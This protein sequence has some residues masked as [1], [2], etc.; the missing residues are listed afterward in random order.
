MGSVPFLNPVA[1]FRRGNALLERGRFA[2][3]E[4]CYRGVLAV[5]PDHLAAHGNLGFALRE[6][7]RHAE[8]EACY[9]RVAEACPEDAEVHYHYGNLLFA[10]GRL[11]EAEAAFRRALEIEP[12][13]ASTHNNLGATLKDLGRYAEAES[14][15]RRALEIQPDGE[16]VHRHSNLLFCMNYRACPP[17]AYREEAIEYGRRVSAMVRE[18]F[19]AWTCTE[20]PERLRVGL[21]SGDLRTHPVGLF[22]EGMLRYIDPA[23]IELFAYPTVPHEDDVTAR[24]KDSFVA[25]R[26]YVGLDDEA[27]ARLTHG[28]GVHVLIDLSGH[29]AHNR[30]PVFAW[31]PAPVQASWLGYFATTGVAEMDYFIGDPYVLPPQDE[32]HFTETTWR[33]P[34]NYVCFAVPDV[35]IGVR[36][37]PALST[38]RVT[39]L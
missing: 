31:K 12:N 39:F 36:P 23:R 13:S 18:R 17:E 33:L 19:S 35:A 4:A 24:L 11:A 15:Y 32:G 8:A 38:G 20:R 10:L 25:W 37:P 22:L 7:G 28:D 29:T 6:Q 3:A 2:E 27:A 26:P 34:E 5:L 9:R 1:L 14:S 21:V 16:G 30:L